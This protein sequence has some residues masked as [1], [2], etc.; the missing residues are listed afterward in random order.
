M[1]IAIIDKSAKVSTADAAL[2]TAACNTQLGL[3]ACPAWNRAPSSVQFFQ[4]ETK[5]P[6]S[7]WI[8]ALF[9][10]ADQSG[11][12]GWHT[13]TP[14]GRPYGRVFVKPVLEAGGTMLTGE[15][16][17]SAVLSHEVLEL[18]VDPYVNLWAT[19]ADGSDYAIEVCDPVES[20]SYMIKLGDKRVSVSNFVLP[21]WFNA[22]P[23][24][25]AKFDYM[26][27]LSSPF[28]MTTGGYVVYKHSG[29]THDRFGAAYP[30][31]KRPGKNHSAARSARRKSRDTVAP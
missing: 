31:W 2:M 12:L 11:A 15:L 26:S 1:L 30:A 21:D 28:A 4:D 27:K 16:S 29:A 23:A 9:D 20:D 7:A 14:A 6:A 5:V 18:V 25:G 24:K 17:V 13:E 10:N 3:H 22:T 19:A 8:I